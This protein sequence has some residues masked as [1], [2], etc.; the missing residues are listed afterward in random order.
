[1]AYDQ[2]L[3]NNE[4]FILLHDISTSSNLEF[5]SWKNSSFNLQNI[6]DAECTAEFRF[7]KSGWLSATIDDMEC[8]IDD[9]FLMTWNVFAFFLSDLLTHVAMETWFQDSEG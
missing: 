5:P 6:S 2:N 3:I 7:P 1:M 9:K 4:E 8:T